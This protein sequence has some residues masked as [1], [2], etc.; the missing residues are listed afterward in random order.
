MKGLMDVQT[1]ETCAY[2][3]IT[4]EGRLEEILPEEVIRRFVAFRKRHLI[5]RFKRLALIEK[6]KIERNSELIRFIKE[7]WN[8]KVIDIKSKADL[9][10]KLKKADFR[11]FE[12]LAS[13]PIYRLT[14]EEVRK[15]KELIE[16]SKKMMAKY[17][18]LVKSDAKLTDFMVE[19]LED[20]KKRWDV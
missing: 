4:S 14:L 7:G 15:C 8:K 2:N 6:D 16:E 12:W 18:G 17:D 19:E 13:M 9:E 1:H 5:R 11:Y 3:M 20:L 10:G